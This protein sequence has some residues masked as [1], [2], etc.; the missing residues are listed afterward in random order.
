MKISTEWTVLA[1]LVAAGCK[2]D[3]LPVLDSLSAL[4]APAPQR[5]SARHRTVPDDLQELETSVDAPFQG[6][7]ADARSIVL[8]FHIPEENDGLRWQLQLIAEE[9]TVL[10]TWSGGLPAGTMRH[11]ERVS[12]DGLDAEQRPLRSGF[13]ALRLTTL[14]GAQSD[15]QETTISAGTPPAPAVHAFPGLPFTGELSSPLR[16]IAQDA[17]GLGY[18]VYL[19]TLHSQTNHSDGGIP[20]ESCD[21]SEVP[22]RGL[23]G[24]AEAFDFARTHAKLDFL[25]TSDHNHMYDGSNGT[26][27]GARTEGVRKLFEAGL[28]QAEHYRQKNP[29]FLALYGTEWGVITRGG[30]VTVV[31]PDGLLN[32]EHNE[33]GELLGHYDVEKNDYAALYAVMKRHGFVGQFNHPKTSQ[34]VIADA[35]MAYSSDGD[36]VMALCE[37]VNADAFS[38]S[39]TES[40]TSHPLFQRAFDRLLERGYHVAPSSDQDNHCANWGI[41]FRNRTGVLLPAGVPLNQQSFL[42]AIRS[43]RVFATMDKDGQAILTTSSGHIMGERFVN[44]GT[45][46]LTVNFAH[47]T[48]LRASRI[49]VFGGIP[50]QSGSTSR[51]SDGDSS[52]SLT[53]GVGPHFYYAVVTESSGDKIWTAPVW[54]EQAP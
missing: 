35:A 4:A 23:Y 37:V 7:Q 24:P 46:T 36:D 9:E 29:E 51:I 50:G 5:E 42:S 6:E 16:G 3:D 41:S 15:R 40:E 10:R 8:S 1:L 39:T 27:A 18:T 38:A 28:E 25:L 48:G 20:T 12:W 34:F 11:R 52:V 44:R 54:V 31:N 49:E 43:R 32:W 26:K 22:Q 45:L 14:V 47:R 17:G 19:G 13:Y 21:G 53:P 33:A 30:H 2:G